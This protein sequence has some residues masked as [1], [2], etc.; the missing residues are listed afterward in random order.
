MNILT[1]AVLQLVSNGEI[2]P[3]EGPSITLRLDDH[4]MRTLLQAAG[5]EEFE[6]HLCLTDSSEKEGALK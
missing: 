6:K 5:E 1:T 2:I 4:L 3:V